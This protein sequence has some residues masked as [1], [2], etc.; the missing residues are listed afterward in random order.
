MSAR[1]AGRDLCVTRTGIEHRRQ[2]DEGGFALMPEATV[3]VCIEA[4]PWFIPDEAAARAAL[5]QPF[6]LAG[7]TLKVA[8]VKRLPMAGEIVVTLAK[9]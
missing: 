2:M 9:A 7:Q 5:G 1:Y 6:T 4:Y 3:R 8:T